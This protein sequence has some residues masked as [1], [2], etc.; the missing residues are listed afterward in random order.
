MNW[1]LPETEIPASLVSFSVWS[2]TVMANTLSQLQPFLPSG[3]LFQHRSTQDPSRGLHCTPDPSAGPRAAPGGWLCGT[4]RVEEPWA[5]V[6]GLHFS[7]CGGEGGR[8]APRAIQRCPC[9]AGSCSLPARHFWAAVLACGA[10]RELSSS[11]T[12]LLCGH[13]G[14]Q[15][16]PG[17]VVPVLLSQRVSSTEAVQGASRK[18]KGPWNS[19]SLPGLLQPERCHGAAVRREHARAPSELCSA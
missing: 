1:K 9:H 6:A 18:P 14:P 19:P 12:G 17:A 15:D 4:A 8:I 2:V 11:G 3:N 13:V 5:S 7:L 10:C 16:V